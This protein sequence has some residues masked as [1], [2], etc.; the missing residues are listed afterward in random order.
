MHMREPLQHQL[1]HLLGLLPQK[2]PLPIDI[3][4]ARTSLDLRSRQIMQM[5]W[6]I[7]AVCLGAGLVVYHHIQPLYF[8]LWVLPPVGLAIINF[9]A[10]QHIRQGLASAPVQQL[11]Q[12]QLRLLALMAVNHTTSGLTI[13]LFGTTGQLDLMAFGMTLQ[14]LYLGLTMVHSC[15]HPPT[16]M[17]GASIN[18]M[19]TGL[20]WGIH[21]PL[22]AWIIMSVLA[23]MGWFMSR[24]CISMANHLRDSLTMRYENTQLLM[25]LGREKKLAEDAMHFKSEFLTNVSHELRTPLTAI[26]G[27]SHLMLKTELTPLQRNHLTVIDQCSQHLHQLVNQ[28]LDFSKAEAHMLQLVNAHFCLTHVLDKVQQMSLPLAKGKDLVFSVHLAPDTPLHLR[29]D[30]LRLVEILVN[31]LGNAIKF[32]A[33]GAISLHIQVRDVLINRTRL[34]FEIR[35]TGRGVTSEQLGQLFQS[36][37]Q[38]DDTVTRQYGGTGLGLAI[39]KKL[40]ELMGG[41][42][43]VSSEIGIG[44]VFWFTAWFDL[45]APTLTTT[46][47]EKAP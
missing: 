7:F 36:F 18:L 23:C 11:R 3:E 2:H 17:V 12:F 10:C 41:E 25:Q 38:G 14:M 22:N 42:V 44:S 16:F 34:Y 1:S 47:T 20:F 46:P 35:D 28:V 24:I 39:S 5:R 4:L 45:H 21:S 30:E 27:M 37:S 29:G 15:T 19:L 31:F 6:V 8:W 13:W 26:M 9:K 33:E 43:G 40:A 32:T